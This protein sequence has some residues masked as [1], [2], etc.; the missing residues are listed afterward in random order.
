MYTPEGELKKLALD[1]D[2][3]EVDEFATLDVATSD[4][5]CDQKA[6]SLHCEAE[7]GEYG[8]PGFNYYLNAKSDA[9]PGTKAKLGIKAVGDGRTATGTVSVT[10]AEGVDLQSVP[11]ESFEAE[12][13]TTVGLI[14]T[15]VHNAG[16][17]TARGVVLRL[18][19]DYLSP[20]AGNFSNCRFIE[21]VQS[22][23]CTI[24]TELEPGKTYRLS[25]KLPVKVDENAR[26]GSSLNS[27]VDWWTK[28]DW[29][30]VEADPSFPLPPGTPGTGKKLSLV[31]VPVARQGTPQTDI[32][33]W[34]SFTEVKI[35]V[36]GGSTADLAAAGGIATGQVGDEVKVSVGFE[37]LGPATVETWRLRGPILEVNIPKGTTAVGVSEECAPMIEDQPWDP[38]ENAG[39]PG[40]RRYGCLTQG[41]IAKGDKGSYEF[42][43]KVDELDH[44][45]SG[46]VETRLAGDPNVANNQASITVKRG[47]AT[48]PGTPGGGE[49]GG[50]DDGPTLPITGDST[51]LIA[52]IG[53]LLLVAGVGGYVVAKR[54]RTRFVA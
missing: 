48:T 3:S 20:Y 42:T 45:T 17:Q 9:K 35:T 1:I 27:Y 47:N 11:E 40:A 54:R 15:E 49:G 29:A 13:G 52:G 19:Q 44:E 23:I 10:V 31:E 12:A 36:L 8:I 33:R 4:W 7:A 28:E 34:N 30:L 24:D 53:G 6:S 18:Q 41:D 39:K 38:W 14:G 43:L 5:S 25:E 16:P 2:L 32:D 21:D 26:A 51:G 46:L 37:N 50:D 22:T